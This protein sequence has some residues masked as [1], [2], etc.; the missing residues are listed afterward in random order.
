MTEK[1]FTGTLN[2]NQNKTKTKAYAKSRFSH[3][4]AYMKKTG[5]PIIWCYCNKVLR[6]ERLIDCLEMPVRQILSNRER[7]CNRSKGNLFLQDVIFNFILL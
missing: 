6:L 4:A 3:D 7:N 2:H 1:L 5:F